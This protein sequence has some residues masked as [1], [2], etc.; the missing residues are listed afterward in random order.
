MDLHEHG[1]ILG[2]GLGLFC[3]DTDSKNLLFK[4]RNIKNKTQLLSFFKEFEFLILKESD[5]AKI[6][7]EF[8]NSLEIVLSNLNGWETIRDYMAIYAIIK[9]K[10]AEYAKKTKENKDVL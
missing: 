1:K 7:K 2:D 3:S 10:N 6:P 9:F 5:K 4:L 8:N